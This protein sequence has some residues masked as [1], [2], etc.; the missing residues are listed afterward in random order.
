MMNSSYNDLKWEMDDVTITISDIE[1]LLS[2]IRL[3]S[4]DSIF[5]LCIHRNK[6]SDDTRQRSHDANLDYPIIV[7]TL[8]NK[9]E[10]VL[11]G[12]HRLLKAK[13]EHRTHMKARL[14][15]LDELPIKYQ[16]LFVA[17]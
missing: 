11:D 7:S 4:I 16:R 3:I 1:P 5:H 12:H 17:T 8:N 6:P 13:S 14:L 9:I 15:A 10:M 2:D